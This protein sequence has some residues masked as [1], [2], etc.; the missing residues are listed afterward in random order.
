MKP[1]IQRRQLLKTVGAFF[2]VYGLDIHA[3]NL[4][5]SAP[6]R[7]ETETLSA[8]VDVLIPRDQY[9]GSATDCQVDK[10]IWSL[11]ESSENFRRLLALGCE[12]LNAT[13]G[14]PFSELSYQ[15]QY[16]L[17]SWMA[18]S[19]WNHVPRRFYEIVRQTALSLYYA[20]PETWQGLSISAPPQPNGYPPPWK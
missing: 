14:P 12:G 20:Q 15:Q 2:M 19:D 16:K 8:F 9:S 17:V 11:A 1:N 4:S 13:D 6:S 7:S 10:Q 5:L 18:E 3:E